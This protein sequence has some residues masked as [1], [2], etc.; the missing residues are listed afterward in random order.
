MYE[1]KEHLENK[2]GILYVGNC[3]A[4]DLAEKYGTPLYVYD[5]NAIRRR[6][7]L[8][9]EKFS[10]YYPKFKLYYAV[11][12]N[13]NLA[14]LKILKSEGVGADC[15]CPAEIELANRAGFSK[16]KI[17]YSG[18]YH[19]DDELEFGLMSKVVINLEDV[20]QIDRLLKFGIPDTIC[21]RV[22]PG[23]GG[24]KYEG[25][26]FAGKDAKFG[27]IEEQILTAYKKAQ[28]YRI[29]KFG[30]HMMTG[31][32]ITDWKYFEAITAKLLDIAGNI[33]KE[34]NLKFEF[35]DIGGGLGVSYKPGE[36]DLDIEK[37]AKAVGEMFKKKIKE[38]DLGE[39]Y[40]KIEPGR[41]LVCEPG[42]LL[43]KVVS[44]KKA[45]KKFI[46]VD[47][48]MNTLL[49]PALYGAYH[50]I[51]IANKLNAPK[52]E[53]VNIV[54]QICE[55]TDQLAKDREMPDINLG[56]TIAILNAGSYG[57]AMGSQYNT[58]PMCAEILVKDGKSTLIRKR[59]TVEDISKNMVDGKFS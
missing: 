33:R 47:A 31:S 15:S 56:D 27:I 1:I 44:I 10:K 25:L 57:Y 53:T 38:H 6:A 55:N 28:R 14:I 16:D 18:V 32:C 17:L 13:N 19:R 5:E 3:N 22:N 11:K 40:L 39:P 42:I 30:I 36:N 35:I 12:A 46:G 23:I 24:G 20:S 52:I 45:Y 58:R 59:E 54:G 2:N 29:K 49:R 9:I 43:A 7:K 21:F 51:V 34:L 4:I 8:L 41:F 50:E 26:V 37:T 48:G